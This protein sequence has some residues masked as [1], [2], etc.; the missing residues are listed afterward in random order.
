MTD[1]MNG[2][3]ASSELPPEAIIFAGKMFDAARNGQIDIFQ[4]ALPAGLPA[5]M[6]NDKGDTLV[7]SSFA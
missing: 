7:G 1:T 5:N 6:R 2:H 3:S 4:Q